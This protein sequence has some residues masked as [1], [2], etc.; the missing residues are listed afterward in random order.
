MRQSLSVTEYIAKESAFEHEQLNQQSGPAA[1]G[2][3]LTETGRKELKR[4]RLQ[5]HLDNLKRSALDCTNC[6]CFNCARLRMI[7]RLERQLAA[8]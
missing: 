5:S 4:I 8:L 6:D 2:K 7:D 3:P 1:L